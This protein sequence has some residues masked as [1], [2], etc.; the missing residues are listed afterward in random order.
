MTRAQSRKGD[1]V[2]THEVRESGIYRN[3]SIHCYEAWVV[4]PHTESTVLVSTCSLCVSEEEFHW[5][6]E[7]VVRGLLG[8]TG[9]ESLLRAA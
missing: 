4:E 8:K 7:R 1:T 3:E 9:P 2:A 5:W 6:E